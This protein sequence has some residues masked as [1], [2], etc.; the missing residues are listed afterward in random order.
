MLAV[1]TARQL[2]EVQ[3]GELAADNITKQNLQQKLAAVDYISCCTMNT[4]DVDGIQQR[5]GNG[6]FQFLSF[7]LLG[8]IYSRGAWHVFGIM[9][10]AGD[11]GH[12][13]ALPDLK[14]G[15]THTDSVSPSTFVD[16][17]R[18]ESESNASVSWTD[19]T[20]P[21]RRAVSTLPTSIDMNSNM[22]YAFRGDSV[23]GMKSNWT[24][25]TCGV[26][27]VTLTDNGSSVT[28]MG[29]CPHGWAYGSEYDST[30][31]SEVGMS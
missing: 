15:H 20:I 2:H 11:P 27:F 8:L 1:Y 17:V 24:A 3:T 7:L 29:E 6:R 13:C 4:E 5:L 22:L 21:D 23:E 9:F 26:S 10:L 18:S 19:G 16:S 12:K 31:L 28:V 30:V 14:N 25:E